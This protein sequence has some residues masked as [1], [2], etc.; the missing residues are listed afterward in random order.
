MGCPL[1]EATPDLIERS[2]RELSST[3]S[4]VILKEKQFNVVDKLALAMT[5]ES[6]LVAIDELLRTVLSISAKEGAGERGKSYLN[7]IILSLLSEEGEC[8]KKGLLHL[9]GLAAK[10]M[11]L[12]RVRA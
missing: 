4:D 3:L 8:V 11:D 5:K 9:W 10:L 2:A 1:D 7:L 12:I 6:A